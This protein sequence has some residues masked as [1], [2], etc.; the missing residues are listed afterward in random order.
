FLRALLALDEVVDGELD[1]G[2]IERRLPELAAPPV[3][4]QA[5]AVAALLHWDQVARSRPDDLWHRPT[6]WRLGESAPFVVRLDGHE[7]SSPCTPG[8]SPSTAA[9]FRWPTTARRTRCGSGCPARTA[10]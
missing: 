7:A 8:P 9:A 2:L 3:T 1:T 6:G 5:L 10:S 4:A